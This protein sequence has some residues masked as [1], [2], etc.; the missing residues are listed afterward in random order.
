MLK[1]LLSRSAPGCH[2][3]YSTCNRSFRIR[4]VLFKSLHKTI[5]SALSIHHYSSGVLVFIY[6]V[7]KRFN[8]VKDI[9]CDIK[10]LGKR[11]YFIRL[12]CVNF[13]TFYYAYVY[14][15]IISPLTG[16]TTRFLILRRLLMRLLSKICS[17]A[18]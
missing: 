8:V 13:H 15:S 17:R 18:S 9:L 10:D 3:R 14:F 5:Y 4:F 11:R 6:V 12:L 16:P 2:H 1:D 7:V